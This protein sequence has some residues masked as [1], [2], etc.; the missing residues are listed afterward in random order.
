MW[1]L[2]D[3]P[4]NWLYSEQSTSITFSIFHCR[5]KTYLLNKSFPP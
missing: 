5:L 1:D 3:I 2:W 4:N